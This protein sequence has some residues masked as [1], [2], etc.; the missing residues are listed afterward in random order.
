MLENKSKVEAMGAMTGGEGEGMGG[1]RLPGSMF[2][3]FMSGE[4]RTVARAGDT[5][6]T[7]AGAGVG[8]GPRSQRRMRR[9]VHLITILRKSH[10]NMTFF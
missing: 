3:K 6:E 2:T 10:A 1:W 4:L 7:L 9:M 5:V 8:A